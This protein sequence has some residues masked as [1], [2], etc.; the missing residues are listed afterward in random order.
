[1]QFRG[2]EEDTEGKGTALIRSVSEQEKAGVA[3]GRRRY[4]REG[5]SLGLGHD[6]GKK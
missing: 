6:S 2:R 5:P 1:M 4:G 3:V